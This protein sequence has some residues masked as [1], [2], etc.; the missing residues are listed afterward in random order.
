MGT[1]SFQSDQVLPQGYIK[2]DGV[3]A[4]TLTTTGISGVLYK[5]ATATNGQV[6]AFNG[7]SWVAQNVATGGGGTPTGTAGGELTGSYPNPTLATTTVVPGSYG[8]ATQVPTFTVD[9][10]G[11]LTAAGSANIAISD[12][13]KLPLTGGSLTGALHIKTATETLGTANLDSDGDLTVDLSSGTFFTVYLN[14]NIFYMN[15]TN[16]PAYLK[17][18][19]F[20]LQIV[21]DGTPRTVTWP[22]VKWPNGIAPA[23]TSTLNK[24]DTFSFVTYDGGMSWFGYVVALKQ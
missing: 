21:A 16:P 19:A 20:I 7:S 22:S 9:S 6:L 11:R 8:S 5:P 15:F 24:T 23:L 3:T 18:Y 2:I 14:R 1:L 17:I 13:T 12:S 4:A 10:K